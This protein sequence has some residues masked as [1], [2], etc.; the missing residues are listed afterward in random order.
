[1]RK[2]SVVHISDLHIR[3]GEENSFNRVRE[4]VV[5]DLKEMIARENF[6]I[7]A[8][9]MT[10]DV[11]DKGGSEKAYQKAN[12]LFDCIANELDLDPKK[13]I[14]VPGNHDIPRVDLISNFF[15]GDK[16]DEFLD[17]NKFKSNWSVLKTR[18]DMFNKFN[19]KY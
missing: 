3:E 9:V 5:I 11:V 1:M 12:V 4:N 19:D 18:F 16:Y 17:V 14:I 6:E 2:F 8:I 15:Q 7:D 10:G 13:I